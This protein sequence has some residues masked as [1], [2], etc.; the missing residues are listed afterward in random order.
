MNKSWDGK[1]KV[2]QPRLDFDGSI[3]RDWFWDNLTY[4]LLTNA[5][6]A[7]FSVGEAFFVRSVNAFRSEIKD[8]VMSE[9]IAAFA[10]QEGNHTREHGRHLV[11]MESQGYPVKKAVKALR[12]IFKFINF[13]ASKKT[14]LAMT[15]GAEHFTALLSAFAFRSQLFEDAHPAMRGVWYWHA[16]E[17]IEHKAVAFDVYKTVAPWGYPRRLWGYWLAGWMVTT[18]ILVG[19]V[20][21]ARHDGLTLRQIIADLRRPRKPKVAALYR[22][23]VLRRLWVYMRP[24]FHPNDHDD[25]HFATNYFSTMAVTAK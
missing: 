2:H 6:S 16:A 11:L 19:F 8:P 15:A 24:S 13:F 14:R 25:Y 7:S 12:T 9:Q 3:R 17:E 5:Y 1:I 4:S 20:I 22:Q 10:A 23:M 21:F 18:Q